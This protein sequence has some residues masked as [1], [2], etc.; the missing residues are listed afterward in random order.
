MHLSYVIGY[1]HLDETWVP[2]QHQ[3]EFGL[4]DF[5]RNTW[6][7]SFC[8]QLLLSYSPVVPRQEQI[9]GD[10]SGTFELNLGIRKVFRQEEP[11]QPHVAAG[12]GIMG[13][14][15]TSRIEGIGYYQEGNE[16]AG[17]YWAN[18]GFY[19]ILSDSYH[20]GISFAYS[21]ALATLFNE[22]LGVGGTHVLFYFGYRW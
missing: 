8:A 17:G 2:A 16:S 14:G 9:I 20:T 18:A 13:V 5:G 4:V 21:N 6:P 7:V 22:H 10:F 15:T 11:I 12:I 3:V 19:W 1:K